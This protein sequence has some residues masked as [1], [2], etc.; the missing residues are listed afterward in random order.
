ML[1]VVLYLCLCVYN[2][3]SYI[4]LLQKFGVAIV[5]IILYH[6]RKTFTP[7]SRTFT[8]PFFLYWHVNQ[9]AFQVCILKCFQYFDKI[10]ILLFFHEKSFE[11]NIAYIF[12][13]L[14]KYAL[15]TQLQW[16]PVIGNT[17]VWR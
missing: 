4:F 3:I 8:P 17:C 10:I 11:E 9:F 13:P 6:V 1:R 14:E 12:S 16:K 15:P 7:R 5:Y 2:N